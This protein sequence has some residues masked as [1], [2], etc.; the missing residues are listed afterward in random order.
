MEN[1]SRGGRRQHESDRREDQ[2]SKC[3]RERY[4]VAVDNRV[5]AQ[6]ALSRTDWSSS[7]A[8][9]SRSGRNSLFP[10]LPMAMAALRRRPERLVRR[11][12]EPRKTSRN[13]SADIWAS[14]ARAGFTNPGRG[15]N[16]VAVDAGALRFHGQTSWQ[17][18]QPKT[19]RPMP[20][21]RCSGIDPRFSI[22]RYEMHL[23]ES[24]WYGARIASVGQASMQRVQVPHRSGAGMS[25]ASSRDVRITPKK[26][27]EPLFLLM[28]Q[29][30]LP[31][32]PTP[33]YFAK[34]R[35]TIGPVST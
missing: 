10:L 7:P 2:S 4:S 29:V 33:A 32:Q 19:W 18:S 14:Q 25:G 31:I 15:S 34:T 30:F 22:V 11:M 12:G 9:W 28:M 1:C 20:T 24:S 6:F 17:I 5:L 35:S 21:R 27:H 8:S 13:S 16:S 3:F 26:N 23:L